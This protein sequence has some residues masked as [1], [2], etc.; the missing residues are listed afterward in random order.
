[1]LEILSSFPFCEA[2]VECRRREGNSFP[3]LGQRPK[4]FD[5]LEV[6]GLKARFIASRVSREGDQS[7]HDPVAQ[8]SYPACLVPK[9]S[10]G[11]RRSGYRLLVD[12]SCT[13]NELGSG[14]RSKGKGTASVAS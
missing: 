2:G 4:G 5:P 11:M 9:Q 12:L 7:F 8:Q 13:T 3:A 14:G 10:L 6:K 1:M